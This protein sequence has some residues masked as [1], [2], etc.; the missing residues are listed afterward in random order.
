MVLISDTGNAKLEGLI[1]QLHLDGNKFNIAVVSDT[2][3]SK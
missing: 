3:Y 1:T 2:T